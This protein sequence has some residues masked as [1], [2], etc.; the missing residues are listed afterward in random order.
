MPTMPFSE[1]I[2]EMVVVFKENELPLNPDDI[3]EA[4]LDVVCAQ[5]LLTEDEANS[6]LA[7]KQIADEAKYLMGVD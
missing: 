7:H 6:D 1:H 5:G 2:E 3:A 4:V